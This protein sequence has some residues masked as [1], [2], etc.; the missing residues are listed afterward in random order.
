MFLGHGV[1]FAHEEDVLWRL[2]VGVWQVVD[3]LQDLLPLLRLQLLCLLLDLALS[4][5]FHHL[6]QVDIIFNVAL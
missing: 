4:H 3:D 2:D 1:H 6:L 5:A